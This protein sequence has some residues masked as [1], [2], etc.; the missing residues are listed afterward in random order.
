[1]D[2]ETYDRWYETPR[3][4]WIGQRE[5]ALLL[6][7]LQ[8]RPGE[9]LLDVGCGTGFFTRALASTMAGTVIGVDINAEW[10]EYARRR[11]TANVSYE[12]ADARALPYRAASFDLV[13]SIA[14]LCFIEEERTAVREMLRVARRRVAIGLLNRRSLLWLRKGRNGGRGGYRGA[15][16]HTTSEAADLFAGL[17]VQRLRVRTAIHLPGGGRLARAMERLWPQ[18]LHTGAFILV[19]ADAAAAADAPPNNSMQRT[20]LRAAADAER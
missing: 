15:R 12:V 1:M 5:V 20:A 16:W 19:V 7:E 18:W 10:V 6:G 2:A 11:N 3:G 13:V 4:R 9:S 14:A 17:P 8:P